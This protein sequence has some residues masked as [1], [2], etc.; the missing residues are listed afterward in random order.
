MSG[1][2]VGFQPRGMCGNDVQAARANRTRR[3]ENGDSVQIGRLGGHASLAKI[4]DFAECNAI[5]HVIMT[6][7][8]LRGRFGILGRTNFSS[9][10]D[11]CFDVIGLQDA[12]KP[13]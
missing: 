1:Q 5:T 6:D 13:F 10:S 2:S 9:K 4:F 3:A 7:Y 11:D 8:A 12:A